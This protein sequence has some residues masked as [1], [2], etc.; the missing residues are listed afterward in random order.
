MFNAAVIGLGRMGISTPLNVRNASPSCCL[1]LAHAESIELHPNFILSG[2]CDSSD[3]ALQTAIHKYPSSAC[4]VDYKELLTIPNLNFISVATRTEPRSDII[5]FFANHK[6][7][8]FH[9]TSFSGTQSP[10][11]NGNIRQRS[12]VCD[13]DR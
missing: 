6:I 7:K 10:I 5:H 13:E 9:C 2:L 4:F 8:H 12:S 1:P 3:Q 11:I